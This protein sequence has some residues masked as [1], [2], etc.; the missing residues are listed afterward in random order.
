[1]WFRKLNDLYG[2]AAS[3]QSEHILGQHLHLFAL[4]FGPLCHHNAFLFENYYGF[5]VS[6]KSGSKII[7]VLLLI[8]K[9]IYIKD[10][11]NLFIGTC[12]NIKDLIFSIC[13]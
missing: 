13:F 11:I 7:Q 3:L 12:R 4:R 5:L 1:M 8:N 2:K 6:H 10:S 9:L